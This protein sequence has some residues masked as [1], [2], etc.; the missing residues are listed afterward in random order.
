VAIAKTTELGSPHPDAQAARS[1]KPSRLI[2][3]FVIL[4][5]ICQLGLLSATL[6]HFRVLFRTA[7]FGLSIA[8]LVLLPG[9]GRLHPAAKVAIF[10]LALLLLEM[11][12]PGV[13]SMLSAAA[14][15]GMYLAILAPL[16]W[17]SRVRIDTHEMRRV[18]FLQWTFQSLSAA[19]GV[20]QVYFPGY[21]QFHV[22]QVVASNGAGYLAMEHFQNAFG[23]L[24]YRPM[25]LTDTPGGAAAAGF[26]A[27]L[28]ATAFFLLDRRR[29]MQFL[30]GGVML[31]GM[32]AIY[33][34]QVRVMLLMELICMAA[35]VGLL[36]LRA[37]RGEPRHARRILNKR[38]LIRLTSLM[39]LV[40]VVGFTWAVA[41][42]G[43][44]ISSRINSLTAS[45]P[46]EV[47]QKNRGQF[48]LYT[49][50]DVLP[51]YPLGAGP[52]RWGMMAYYF[53]N[54]G[55]VHHP[56]LWSEI[57]WTGWLYDGGVPM[58]VL[59]VLAIT[60]A[61]RVAYKI[62]LNQRFAELGVLGAL[63]FAFNVSVLAATFDSNYFI[64]GGGMDFWLLNAMLFNAAYH[65]FR[66]PAPEPFGVHA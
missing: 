25:G 21:F 32:A 61:M 50:E 43:T 55:D 59:Y 31:M 37:G 62:A 4:E 46:G 3:R 48:L 28:F 18:L 54:P 27:V 11:L 15:F 16:F 20:L 1:P 13:N 36:T 39:G 53:G 7:A 47:Y 22:S 58:V 52:G 34:S 23:E 24:V 2:E 57:Q 14:Q 17:V 40:V 42:G 30:Y 41:V 49:V 65:T 19:I 9:R 63:V 64:S 45:N 51:E 8:L 10:I 60:L 6:A 66:A 5:I 38:R 26:I 12:N 35:M 44:A 33:L 56:Y 29:K